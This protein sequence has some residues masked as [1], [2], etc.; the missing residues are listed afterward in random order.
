MLRFIQLHVVSLCVESLQSLEDGIKL[1][2]NEMTFIA[3][4]LVS[5]K[6]ILYRMALLPAGYIISKLL[7]DMYFIFAS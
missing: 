2:H 5:P 1:G 6:H 4:F 3:I 7:Q